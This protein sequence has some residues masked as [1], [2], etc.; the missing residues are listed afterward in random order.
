[1]SLRSLPTR[2]EDLA[3]P[4]YVYVCYDADDWVLYVGLSKNV[5]N[6]I[7][8]HVNGGAWWLDHL[9]HVQALGPMPYDD[10]RELEAALIRRLA[11]AA[12]RQYN[13]IWTAHDAAE[14]KEICSRA[15]EENRKAE[16]AQMVEALNRLRLPGDLGRPAPSMSAAPRKP[17][18]NVAA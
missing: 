8:M 16:W 4:H 11:P 2:A 18:K 17:A 1:M 3:L 13:E 5:A 7:G 6:R 9:R 15:R 12:N 14:W 10:A